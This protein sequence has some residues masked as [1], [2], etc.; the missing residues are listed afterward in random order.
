MKRYRGFLLDADNTLF[1]YDRAEREALDE[2][3]A[4]AAPAAPREEARAA[5]REI[6]RGYWKRFE[7]GAIGLDGLKVGRFADLLSALAVAGDPQTV[8]AIYLG[9]LAAKAYFLPHA[10]ETLDALSRRSRLCLV[11]NGISSVQRGRLAAAGIE[12]CFTAVLISEELGFAKPDPRFFAAAVE[13]LGLQPAELLCV[14]DSPTSDVAGARAAGID[15]CW[16]A[17][18]AA[19]W[20]GPGQPPSLVVGDL[21]ELLAFAP[22]G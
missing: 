5:Y 3:L 14:G 17:P 8:S 20:P 21:A 11:T 12:A 10:R 16:Y 15:A 9:K 18:S 22:H 6:N 1:D 4:K 19:A 2:T 13:S 7:Q